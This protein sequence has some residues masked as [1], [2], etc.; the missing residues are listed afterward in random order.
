MAYIDLSGDGN[1]YRDWQQREQ[2]QQQAPAQAPAPADA[3]APVDVPT[4]YGGYAGGKN[5][6]GDS[7]RNTSQMYDSNP[8][9]GGAPST[10]ASSGS[11]APAFGQPS[12]NASQIQQQYQA[13]FGRAA[14]DAE[15]RSEVENANKYGATGILNSIKARANN[16]AASGVA[17]NPNGPQ[18]INVSSATGRLNPVGGTPN[19]SGYAT[20]NVPNQPNTSPQFTDPS[21][22]LLES[23]ALNRYQ[24]LQNPD[25]NSGAAMYESYAKQLVD[26]L[27]SPAYSAGDEA[28]IKAGAYNSINADEQAT[29]QQWLD[30]ISRRGLR[31]SDGPALEGLQRIKESFSK[32]RAS[33]DQQFAVNAINLGRTDRLQALDVLGNLQTSENTRLNAAEHFARVPYDLGTDAFNQNMQAVQAGGQ[34]GANVGSLIQLATAIQGANNISSQ[35]RAQM[36]QEIFSVLGGL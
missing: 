34:P 6:A 23:Y 26:R 22:Q 21:Q 10:Q 29:M 30:E 25:P 7:S 20:P 2:D 1:D 3:P 32:V 8:P 14:T 15:L 18:G 19:F 11:G 28:A 36:L 27:K 13:S 35:Q 9:S 24:N 17:G 33:V 31:P 12:L 16:V 5:P 4:Y